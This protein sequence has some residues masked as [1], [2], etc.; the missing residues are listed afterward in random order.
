MATQYVIGLFFLL[1][2]VGA[3]VLFRFFKSSALIKTKTYQAGGALAG[4]VIIFGLLF[5]A[6][7][8]V[9][10]RHDKALDTENENLKDENA[11]LTQDIK[12]LRALLPVKGKVKPYKDAV[13][14]FLSVANP[15]LDSLDGHFSVSIPSFV[16]EQHTGEVT[17]LAVVD[18]DY[19]LLQCVEGVEEEKDCDAVNYLTLNLENREEDISIPLRVKK[20]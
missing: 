5:G 4:F 10:T 12:K 11:T 18:D 13:Q 2:L 15:R 17:L 3:V 20:R 8:Q 9:E 19:V 14:I 6:Y 7:D 16:F 1:S